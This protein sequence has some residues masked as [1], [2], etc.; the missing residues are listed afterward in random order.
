M[1]CNK[2]TL[3]FLP[4][5]NF[6]QTKLT[7]LVCS[8]V[9][10]YCSS[11]HNLVLI[12]GLAFTLFFYQA[13]LLALF[14]KYGNNISLFVKLQGL[15]IFLALSFFLTHQ[16]PTTPAAVIHAFFLVLSAQML[17]LPLF[18]KYTPSL[19]IFIVIL[20]VCMLLGGVWVYFN[21]ASYT[22]WSWDP[23]EVCSLSVFFSFIWVVHTWSYASTLG[24]CIF[25]V[26]LIRFFRLGPAL[27]AHHLINNSFTSALSF[28]H[29]TSYNFYCSA[30]PFLILLIICI[31]KLS[32]RL[33]VKWQLKLILTILVSSSFAWLCLWSNLISKLWCLISLSSFVMFKYRSTFLSLPLKPHACFFL[34]LIYVNTTFFTNTGSFLWFF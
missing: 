14:V 31:F 21:G 13:P 16:T 20:A 12:Q 29:I 1:F 19:D 6:L 18:T 11:L 23:V 10:I 17:I 32:C 5:L 30:S 15:F 9:L 27:S 25:A 28:D 3:G 2:M 8:L 33:R 26:G 7:P 22:L 4:K 24:V 34:I